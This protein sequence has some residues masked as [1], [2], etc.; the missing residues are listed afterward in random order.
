MDVSEERGM[1]RYC[2]GSKPL[3][4][5]LFQLVA[6]DDGTGFQVSFGAAAL[7]AEGQFS[8]IPRNESE[9]DGS[10]SRCRQCEIQVQPFRLLSVHTYRTKPKHGA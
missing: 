1:T 8:Q 2:L 4:S 5:L 7:K 3:V 10:L 9:K 6:V